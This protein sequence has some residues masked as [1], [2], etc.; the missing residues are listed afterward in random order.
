M[1]RTIGHRLAL[2]SGALLMLLGMLGWL[3]GGPIDRWLHVALHFDGPA[4]VLH[5]LRGLT[6]L[7]GGWVMIPVA[8]AGFALLALRRRFGLALWLL[9]TIATGRIVVELA[10][11]GFDRPRPPS[12]DRLADVTSLS[13]P[14]SHAAGTVLTCAALCLALDAS[15]AAWLACGVFAIAIGLTRVLLGV[16][17][18]SDV[19]AG[20]GFGLFWVMLCACWLP[21]RRAA[22]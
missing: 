16:H 14:S 12:A 22:A 5:G 18:P 19:L 17:W 20:W 1:T 15:R 3:V 10:K 8:L 7:G 2:A 9:A 13:F 6:D 4:P 21:R 11:I